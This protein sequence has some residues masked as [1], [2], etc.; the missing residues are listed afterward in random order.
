[1]IGIFS[2]FESTN[3]TLFLFIEISIVLASVAV[4]LL[5]RIIYSAL[6][7]GFI[8]INVALIYLLLGAEFLAAAQVLIYVGAINVLIL[9]AIMLVSS[10]Y[11]ETANI[12]NA[13]QKISAFVL[14]AL[15]GLLNIVIIETPWETI[16]NM[17]RTSILLDPTSQYSNI[18]LIGIN[19]FQELLLP[20]E[21]LSL[22]LLV[23][24]V[25]AITIARKETPFD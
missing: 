23:A 8:F 21:L 16:T 18:A 11:G 20:F 1:V 17:N 14:I 24:L 4:I 7:L 2:F 10:P 9:F 3:S 15:F 12:F 25:G 6:S 22:L 13:G 5:P 19:L